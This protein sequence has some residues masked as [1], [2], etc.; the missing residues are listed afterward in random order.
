MF[1]NKKGLVS[2]NSRFGIESPISTSKISMKT[3][4]NPSCALKTIDLYLE[5]IYYKTIQI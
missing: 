4:Y 1:E 3:T 5:R 2:K